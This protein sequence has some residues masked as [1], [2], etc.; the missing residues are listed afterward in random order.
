MTP[1]NKEELFDLRYCKLCNV[2]ERVFGVL[3]RRFKILTTKNPRLL[4]M[5]AQV[6][7]I[8]VLTLL[9]NILIITDEEVREEVK[10]FIVPLGNAQAEDSQSQ[11]E[12]DNLSGNHTE[13]L[14]SS[15]NSTGYRIQR[16]ETKRA[17]IRRDN[18]AEAMW[19]DYKGLREQV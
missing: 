4:R 15:T 14:E 11:F 2:I 13:V 5:K 17:R 9:H 10:K 6:R 7:V 19:N 16:A 1:Q 12:D 18:I 8:S 3:K